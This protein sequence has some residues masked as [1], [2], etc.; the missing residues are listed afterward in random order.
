MAT[1]RMHRERTALRAAAAAAIAAALATAQ[2]P[3]FKLERDGRWQLEREPEPGSD[4]AVVAE[5]RR[6]LA[7]GRPG[8]AHARIDAWIQANDPDGRGASPWLAEAYLLRGD[9]LVAQDR[10]FKALFDYEVVASRFPDSTAFVRAIEREVEIAVMYSHGLRRRVWG[11]RIGAADETA[12]ELLIRAQERL[13]GSVV[14][15]RAAIELADH[16][17]RQRE[18]KLAGEAYDL[19]LQNYPSGASRVKAMQRRIFT[20]IARFKGPAYDGAALIDAQQQIRRFS[21]ELPGEAERLGIN[22]ALLSRVDESLAQQRL[23]TARWR[24]EQGD[25]ASARYLLRRVVREH[26]GSTAASEAIQIMQRREWL[27]PSQEASS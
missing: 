6:Q 14:A 15:E 27:L 5:A 16:Y 11:F 25:L 26:P 4:E 13:P 17:F 23:L 7:E 19:Y 21:A 9:A 1:K 12:V 8:A 24:L 10:E 18:M 20:N 3:A 2:G 22:D